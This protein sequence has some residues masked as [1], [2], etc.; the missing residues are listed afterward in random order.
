MKRYRHAYKRIL[1][2]RLI[3]SFHVSE[4]KCFLTDMKV[5]F[6]VVVHPRRTERLLQTRYQID[7]HLTRRCI[8]RFRLRLVIFHVYCFVEVLTS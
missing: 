1:A 6:H 8:P 4:Q 5:L 2:N 7:S 3:V